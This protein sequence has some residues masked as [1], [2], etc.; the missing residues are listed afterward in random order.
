[1]QPDNGGIMFSTCPSVFVCA[2]MHVSSGGVLQL[3]CHRLLVDFC[4]CTTVGIFVSMFDL[5]LPPFQFPN[6]GRG[7]GVKPP[8]DGGPEVS[9]PEKF[10]NSVCD[11][12]HFGAVW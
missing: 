7:L 8:A 5:G 3:A 9:P 10:W 11:L 4:V 2:H 12:V 6:L 1:M